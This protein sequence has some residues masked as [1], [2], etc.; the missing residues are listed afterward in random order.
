M[1]N[2]KSVILYLLQYIEFINNYY[3]SYFSICFT[4]FIHSYNS[5][6]NSIDIQLN[7]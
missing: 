5:V 4:L 1:C 6:Q 7:I 2:K 3:V